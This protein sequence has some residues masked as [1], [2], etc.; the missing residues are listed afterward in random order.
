LF[1]CEIC[2]IETIK[3]YSL[4]YHINKYHKEENIS[5]IDNLKNYY[6]KYL[7]KDDKEKICY[8]C[9][10]ELEFINLTK[11]YGNKYCKDKEC[12][13]KYMKECL[14]KKYGVDNIFK[15]EE[16]KNIARKTKLEKYGDE[17]YN[18]RKKFLETFNKKSE[19]EIKKEYEIREK[20][21]KENNNIKYGV[22]NVFQLKEIIEKSKNTCIEKY[23][24]DNYAKTEKHII[25]LKNNK[26]EFN[27][28]AK[29]TKLEKYGDENYH[30]VKK[31]IETNLLKYGS[32]SILGS[33]NFNK[34]YKEKIKRTL[35]LKYGVDHIW[36]NKD[37]QQEM[38]RKSHITMKLN[39]LYRTSKIET[40]FLNLLTQNNIEYI[41]QYRSEK[42]PFSC[43]FY[44]P[45]KDL[46]IELHYYFMHGEEP[47]DETKHKSLINF[48]KSKCN[49]NPKYEKAI[50]TY[51]DLDVRKRNIAQTNKLNFIEVYNSYD[52]NKLLNFILNE[53]ISGYYC[54]TDY[55]E[56]R[57]LKYE[58]SELEL[59]LELN[60]LIIKDFQYERPACDNKI[61]LTF[62]TDYF[63]KY[64]NNLWKNNTIRKFL[65]DNR[66]QYLNKN[67]EDLTDKELLRS[68]KISGKYI[69][70]S[71]FS[72]FWIKTF[73]TEFNI[74]SVY[75]PCGGWGHR[76]LGA[77]NI[78]YI[79]ND[80]DIIKLN[81]VKEIFNFCLTKSNINN[82][83]YF[84][85][86]DASNFTPAENYEA[87]FTCPPYW[88]TEYYCEKSSEIQYTKYQDWLN[89]WWRNV[90]KKSNKNNKYFCYVI[91]TKYKNDM[92]EICLDEGLEYVGERNLGSIKQQSH[93]IK[94]N[95]KNI[96]NESLQIFINKKGIIK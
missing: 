45:E 8:Y 77:L 14:V 13:N 95:K 41:T 11:G 56:Y 38:K 49:K 23:N 51:T 33:K 69:G 18:N 88:N 91:N 66:L 89:I 74:Q 67:F 48:W 36:K 64:E 72:P 82:D 62:Q 92:N 4:A 46:Y 80:I 61:I 57:Y 76:L 63:Y 59:K 24:T 16:F 84:Y 68:F 7:L 9:E 83:K 78:K 31:M 3:I 75:D 42:Y 5:K 43:D 29:Q 15:S 73:L 79:Y 19:E 21:K 86:E 32:N 71:H 94:N 40:I 30:N 96:N 60:K 35:L 85:N 26:E 58:Y 81:N 53:Y 47:Y 1:K 52:L 17:N 54:L 87:V 37:I 27:K 65:K 25:F 10:K 22:D 34:K 44:L 93:L 28:K 90:I 20:T 12:I 70:F 2:G 6:D 50:Y 39:K 55:V